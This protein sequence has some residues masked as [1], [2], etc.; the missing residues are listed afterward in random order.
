MPSSR[1]SLRTRSWRRCRSGSEARAG[2]QSEPLTSP[3]S[4]RHSRIW[5]Q[6]TRAWPSATTSSPYGGSCTEPSRGDWLGIPPGG[7]TFAVPFANVVPFSQGL[8]AG[9]RIYFD[10]ATLCEQARLPLEEV[11]GLGQGLRGFLSPVLPNQPLGVLEE[12]DPEPE[13]HRDRPEFVCGVLQ[14]PFDPSVLALRD[15][16]LRPKALALAAHG[17]RELPGVEPFQLGQDLLRTLNVAK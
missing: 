8:M 1:P 11:D 10:L 15:I 6:R 7:G 2:T 16:D 5:L 13:R 9:E 17:R 4:S 14:P 12:R 3:S